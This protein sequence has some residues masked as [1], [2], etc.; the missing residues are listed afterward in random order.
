MKKHRCRQNSLRV[1][2]VIY[3]LLTFF[4]QGITL[5]GFIIAGYV[6]QILCM[7][8]RGAFSSP[9]LWADL[10]RPRLLIRSFI[11][12]SSHYYLSVLFRAPHIVYAVHCTSTNFFCVYAKNFSSFNFQNFTFRYAFL[13]HCLSIFVFSICSNW[14][15]F[16]QWKHKNPLGYHASN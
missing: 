1:S 16:S 8:E 13:T 15:F 9:H 3:I 2:N 7:G 12:P 10:K 4:R 5:Q 14:R 11:W 6:S